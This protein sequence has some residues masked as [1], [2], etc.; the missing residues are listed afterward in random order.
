MPRPFQTA[1]CRPITATFHSAALSREDGTKRRGR[2]SDT[3]ASWRRRSTREQCLLLNQNID[4]TRTEVRTLQSRGSTHMHTWSCNLMKF[5]CSFLW[6]RVC[7]SS[8][9][10]FRMHLGRSITELEATG[11]GNAAGAG[12]TAGAVFLGPRFAVLKV[13]SC[14][15]AT[16]QAQH[17]CAET[18]EPVRIHFFLVFS[19]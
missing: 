3:S 12:C 7:A 1:S 18:P 11:T 5:S 8:S 6:R 19:D 4:P 10:C 13:I 9:A 14:Y 16:G 2:G 15:R 17:S